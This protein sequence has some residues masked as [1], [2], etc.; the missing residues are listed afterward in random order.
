M[1]TIHLHQKRTE[2]EIMCLI[3][4]QDVFYSSKET[5]RLCFHRLH[6]SSTNFVYLCVYTLNVLSCNTEYMSVILRLFVY[7]LI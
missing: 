7:Y 2:V 4:M 6:R 3:K 5:I 1:C